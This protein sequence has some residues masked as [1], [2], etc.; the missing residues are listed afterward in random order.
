M[1]SLGALAE[2]AE[3]L[4][5]VTQPDRPSGRGLATKAP[6]VKLAALERGYDVYQPH[7]VRTGEL[8]RWVSERAPDVALVI[9][10]GRILPPD[11]LSAP[12]KGSLNLHASLLPKYRGAA[13][14]Q[15]A[16]ASGERETGVSLM[17]MDEGLDTGPVFVREKL[18][19]GPE[20]SG[21]EL[22][23]RIAEL[24]ALV[25]RRH[26]ERCVRGELLP[27]PQDHALATQAPPI[28]PHH[29]RVDGGTT[30]HAPR[31]VEL[32]R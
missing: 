1:P 19:I 28:E 31:A 18:A 4:G 30:N 25:V 5:V 15:W 16:I 24:A 17:Q 20:E 2:V 3:V 14:I 9:A 32:Y 6:A 22:A 21:G 27:E 29:R 23:A 26:L 12:R 10:Y 13:P 8:G 11:V 7:K